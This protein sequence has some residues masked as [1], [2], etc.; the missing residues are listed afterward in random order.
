[1][2]KTGKAKT[3]IMAVCGKG[4]V[5]KT[6]I[7]AS[8]IRILAEDLNR[9]VLAIDADPA[10]GLATA[11]GF[12]PARTVDE[13]RNDLISRVEKGQGGDKKELLKQLDYEIFEALTEKGNLA[14]LAIGRPEKVGCYCQ[15]NDFLKDVIETIAMNFDYVVIDGEAGIEQVNR[16]VME[17]VTHLLLVS[18]ASMKGITVIKTIKEVSDSAIAYDEAGLILNRIRGSEEADRLSI[19]EG[20][21]LIGWVPEDDMIRETDIQG[22]SIMNMAESPAIRAVRKILLSFNFLQHDTGVAV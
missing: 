19:P 18:D 15:V 4:G 6:S 1:M 12:T 7:S 3:M 20:I 9:K 2:G 17:S 14:F 21:R 8:I 11:L 13:I 5:G 16:R 10:V 22:K